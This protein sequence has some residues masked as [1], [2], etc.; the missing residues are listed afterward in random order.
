MLIRT[1]NALGKITANKG[2]M[3]INQQLNVTYENQK[4]I[5]AEY[6]EIFISC[7]GKV[8]KSQDQSQVI[9]RIAVQS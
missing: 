7:D 5:L 4:W 3:V 2:L 8:E 1:M 6:K 9:I